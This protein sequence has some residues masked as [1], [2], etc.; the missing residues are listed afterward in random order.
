MPTNEF[1]ATTLRWKALD[2]SLWSPGLTIPPEHRLPKTSA[3]R[4][5]HSFSSNGRNFGGRN[6]KGSPFV[7]AAV[8]RLIDEGH[9][10]ELLH[11]TEVMS[12]NM[13][14][15]QAQADIVVEQLIYG[16]WGSTG[17]ETMALGKPVVCYLR[18]AWKQAFLAAF[19][20][21]DELPVIEAN[22][23]SVYQVLKGLVTDA[24][25]RRVAGQRSRAFALRHFDPTRNAAELGVALLGIDGSTTCDSRI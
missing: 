20:E 22:T 24:K 17:V 19:P 12:R 3:L 7:K 25:S 9:D 21:Y 8:D 18:P 2:L 16:W 23:E 5:V 11:L 10:V 1:R 15:Y 4:I 6:I 13:R 14:Y